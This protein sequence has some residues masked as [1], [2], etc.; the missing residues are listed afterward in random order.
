M[1][2][3]KVIGLLILYE[4]LFLISNSIFLLLNSDSSDASGDSQ[5]ESSAILA[6][7]GVQLKSNGILDSRLDDEDFSSR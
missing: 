2:M 1:M 6:R 3:M 4:I 7:R 5:Y